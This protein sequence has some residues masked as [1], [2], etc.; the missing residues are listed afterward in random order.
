VVID[1]DA[2]ALFATEA[3]AGET[4]PGHFVLTPHAGEYRRMG[5]LAA[6]G[7][8]EADPE[9]LALIADARDFAR[10]R[11]VTLVLKGPVTL[12]ADPD[13]AVT[14]SASGHP[15]MATAGTGDVLAGIAGRLLALRPAAEAAPLAVFLHG[16]AGEAARRDRG[17]SGMTASD[18][19]LYLPLAIKELEDA[20]AA[21]DDDE[22]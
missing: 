3:G 20:L 10:R 9:P 15:G 11:G 17:V 1:G 22:D 5:G 18:L 6:P 16:R 2:L 14:A 12:C 4:V 13:G 21:G 19:I 8:G 7:S